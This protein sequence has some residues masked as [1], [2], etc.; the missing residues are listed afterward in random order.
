MEPRGIWL[1]QLL[2]PMRW[3]GRATA[4]VRNMAPPAAPRRPGLAMEAG[5][6]PK[7]AMMMASSP[8]VI[9][10]ATVIQDQDQSWCV[11]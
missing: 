4:A 3:A 2:A 9:Q 1:M 6:P 7:L 5:K 11:P 8:D 10:Q